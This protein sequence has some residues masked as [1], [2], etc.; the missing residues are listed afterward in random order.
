MEDL[1][2]RGRFGDDGEGKITRSGDAMWYCGVTF[3]V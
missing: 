1:R 3:W 2:R